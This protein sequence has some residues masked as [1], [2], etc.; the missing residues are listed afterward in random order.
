MT[1]TNDDF[2]DMMSAKVKKTPRLCVA[3][4]FWVCMIQRQRKR[5]KVDGAG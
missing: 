1:K 3:F 4:S 2:F 5:T